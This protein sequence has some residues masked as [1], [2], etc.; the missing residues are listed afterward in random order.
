MRRSLP[1]V[2]LAVLVGL[3]S[4]GCQEDS[5][6][7]IFT[8]VLAGANEVPPVS[9]TGAGN[10]AV[11]IDGSQGTFTVDVSSLNDITAAH[12]HSGAVGVNG[13]VRVTLFAGPTTTI[14][15]RRTLTQGTFTAAD[16]SGIDFDTLVQQLRSGDAYVNVHT[17]RVPSGE[18]RGQLVQVQ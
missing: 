8:A 18:V 11:S 3:G 2:S 12:I 13:P 4:L 10:A 9:T 1:V 14:G 6:Q 17:T 15:A 16:V 7:E 5:D